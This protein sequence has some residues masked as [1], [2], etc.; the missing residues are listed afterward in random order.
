LAESQFPCEKIFEHVGVGE[1]QYTEKRPNGYLE[2]FVVYACGSTLLTAYFI[3][4]T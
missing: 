4:T 3:A 1:Q 2:P